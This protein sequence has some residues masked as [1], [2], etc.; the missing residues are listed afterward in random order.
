MGLNPRP[1]VSEAAEAALSVFTRTTIPVQLSGMMCVT[2]TKR[3]MASISCLAGKSAMKLA[4]YASVK[5]GKECRPRTGTRRCRGAGWCR[6]GLARGGE[7][8]EAGEDASHELPHG[9]DA[10][11]DVGGSSHEALEGPA[12]HG[13]AG[14]PAVALGEVLVELGHRAC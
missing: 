9:R 6:R 10:G 5:Q 4:V 2:A 8:S 11:A 1:E 13:G 3:F 12:V 7:P 14:Y